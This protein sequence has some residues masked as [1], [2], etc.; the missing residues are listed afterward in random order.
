MLF[1]FLNNLWQT[2]TIAAPWL[3]LGLLI[4]GLI[5]AK[6]SEKWIARHLSGPGA[7]P[8]IKG[9]FIGAP[10]PLCSCSVIPV[11]TQI[12]RS[13]ASKGATASF[14][15]STP[16]TGVDSISLSYAL[17]GPFMAIVRPVAAVISAIVTGLAVSSAARGETSTPA[18]ESASSSCSSC[19]G[20]SCQSDATN[21]QM[22][23]MQGIHY[24]FTQMLDDMKNWLLIGLVLSALVMTFIPNDF[25]LAFQNSWWIYLLVFVASF[26]V[27]ICAS[28]ST[29]VA[30][31]LM[32]AGLSPGATLIFMLAGP[33][34]NIGTLGILKQELGARAMQ[35]YVVSL[36]ILSISL[37][38]ATDWLV[39]HYDFN[40]GQQLMQTHEM[41]PLWVGAL[42]VAV[43]FF[44]GSKTLRSK[45][46]PNP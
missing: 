5:K 29:P 31:S 28:A 3:I 46:L 30:A 45:V 1:D 43:L 19:C 35:T 4:A 24:A 39:K 6:V 12:H 8:V 22:S 26:P 17:L 20:S 33:S 7:M 41:V 32:L 9:A 13:G 34:T 11:A 37:G 42:S 40:I 44:F 23:L 2:L 14:L 36:A 18:T 25:L 10:L 38:V 16:E 27:Y 15:V 21:K